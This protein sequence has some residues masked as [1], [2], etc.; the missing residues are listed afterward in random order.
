MFRFTIRE[1]V[2]LTLVVA[3]GVEW[4]VD[5]RSLCGQ[6]AELMHD[7]LTT[8]LAITRG[9]C[10]FTQDENGHTIVAPQPKSNAATEQA[11]TV[12]PLP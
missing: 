6:I 8:N 11:Q 10:Y 1:L 7:T 4:G 3:M 5:R 2:L 9:G 12:S